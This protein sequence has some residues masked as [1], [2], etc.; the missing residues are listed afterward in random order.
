MGR[1]RALVLVALVAAVQIPS[2]LANTEDTD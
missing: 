1:I 2:L